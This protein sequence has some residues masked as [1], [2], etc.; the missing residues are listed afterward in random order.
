LKEVDVEEGVCCRFFT[1]TPFYLSSWAVTTGKIA[2]KRKNR[3]EE[4][5][6]S[7]GF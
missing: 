6:D 7:S 2:R 3:K 4:E 1:K 5:A